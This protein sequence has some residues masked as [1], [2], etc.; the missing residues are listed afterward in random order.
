MKD[1]VLLFGGSFDPPHIGHVNLLTNA[2]KAVCP[3]RVLVVPS[4][5]SPHK[6]KSETPFALRILMCRCF[7]PVCPAVELSDMEER[8]PG[9]SYTYDTVRILQSEAPAARLFLCMG[10]DMLK[11]FD[12]WYR[13]KDLLALVT[14]VAAAREVGQDTEMQKVAQMLEM[15]GGKVLL[16]EGPVVPAASADIRAR[17]AAGDEAALALV[18]PPA[19][20][21][22]LQNGLYQ[23]P[24]G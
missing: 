11:S 6:Q 15:A 2:A 16:A 9:K 8:R 14:L 21:V 17:L 7:L 12:T 24:G 4:A 19:D 5:T 10:G 22:V 23:K 3:G 20:E 1:D 18:P 13:W